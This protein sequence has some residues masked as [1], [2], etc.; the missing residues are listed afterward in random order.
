M[1]FACPSLAAGALDLKLRIL[2]RQEHQQKSHKENKILMSECLP[3]A[4]LRFCYLVSPV[5]L[6]FKFSSSNLFLSTSPAVKLSSSPSPLLNKGELLS[7][8]LG[9]VPRNLSL[10]GIISTSSVRIFFWK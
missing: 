8:R 10:H 9:L 1:L 5:L 7:A 3:P 2:E 6:R 4:W